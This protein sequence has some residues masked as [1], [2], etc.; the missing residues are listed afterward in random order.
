MRR[1][2]HT[3][4]CIALPLLSVI[5][6]WSVLVFAAAFDG[7]LAGVISAIVASLFLILMLTKGRKQVRDKIRRHRIRKHIRV[8]GVCC[9]ACDKRFVLTIG[10]EEKFPWEK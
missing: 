8:S 7:D 9:D 5:L 6:V 2:L 1:N 3:F 4:G 10:E